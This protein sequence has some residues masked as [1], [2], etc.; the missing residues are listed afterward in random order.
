MQ[1][2]I[3]C[4]AFSSSRMRPVAYGTNAG[5]TS[6]TCASGKRTAFPASYQTSCR[7]LIMS[8]M[9]RRILAYPRSTPSIANQMWS[10]S[11]A[12]T[13]PEYVSVFFMSSESITTCSVG[14]TGT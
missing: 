1:R 13:N 9:T 8:S 5:R 14:T 4:L 2:D 3:Q 6:S 12:L 10:P 11:P 7:E